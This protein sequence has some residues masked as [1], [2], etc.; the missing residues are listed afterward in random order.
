VG[1]DNERPKGDHFHLNGV[2]GPYRFLDVD[3][4]IEDFMSEVNVRRELK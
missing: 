1:F 2:E 3:K 4:L